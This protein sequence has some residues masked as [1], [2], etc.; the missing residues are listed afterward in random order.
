MGLSSIEQQVFFILHGF[1]IP[2][3]NQIMM[4]F[5]GATPWLPLA[6]YL[7]WKISKVKSRRDT[8]VLISLGIMLLAMVDTSTSYF[9]KNLIRRLRP[10][11][12]PE[13]KNQIAQFGQA[14]GGKW[15]FFSSHAANS[16]ALVSFLVPFAALSRLQIFLAISIVTIVCYSRI[17]LG[18]HL[19]LDIIAGCCWGGALSV[20][21]VWIAKQSITA[22][23]AV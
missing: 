1:N 20:S 7:M 15:G 9:F 17:Y 22:P 3:I 16:V 2:G 6:G 4:F 13:L 11:K 14:C 8:L 5:S 23:G 21:W 19:P 12:M 18:V 10:C